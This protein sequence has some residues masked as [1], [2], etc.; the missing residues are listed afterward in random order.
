[1][2]DAEYTY[3]FDPKGELETNYITE[4]HSVSPQSNIPN[5]TPSFFVVVP[6][7]AP[8]LEKDLVVEHF[9]NNGSRKLINGLDYY[10]AHK[11]VSASRS[12][13][14]DVY[15]AIAINNMRLTGQL[16]IN[17]RPLGGVWSL[18]EGEAAVMLATLSRNPRVTTW[19][20]LRE[21]P[22][23]FPPL[24]HDWHLE[25][26]VG[27]SEM[28]EAIESIGVLLGASE[29]NELAHSKVVGNPHGTTAEDLDLEHLPNFPVA[30]RIQMDEGHSESL[31]TPE[32]VN[33]RIDKIV[34]HDT[35]E[36]VKIK[37]VNKN[38]ADGIRRYKR[39][40]YIDKSA[41]YVSNYL[42]EHGYPDMTMLV[43][44]TNYSGVAK[45]SVD[46]VNTTWRLHY[47]STTQT[48]LLNKSDNLFYIRQIDGRPEVWMSTDVN[49][50][51]SVVKLTSN[52]MFIIDVD[53]EY[54][55]EVPV[56]LKDANITSSS[57]N[58]NLYTT[59]DDINVI[60]ES[61]VAGL[62]LAIDIIG[63]NGP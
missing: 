2:S 18:N 23:A 51:V 13:G 9:S 26:M 32:L 41:G 6:K 34:N 28:V 20:N 17:Y 63:P 36:I 37:N 52:D 46:L 31:V 12:I 45:T 61:V 62:S 25:D 1:M 19:E 16:R 7:V 60:S 33:Y 42:A 56:F 55:E 21:L 59:Y 48:C 50:N 43:T 14:S 15:G 22:Y 57:D 54:T 53:S 29:N 49:G 27:L 30:T 11:F 8:F 38:T 5:G 4:L 39:I 35:S 3:P 10:L 40:A 24:D 44:T 47:V 58:S